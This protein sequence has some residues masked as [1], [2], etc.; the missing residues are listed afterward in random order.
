[1]PKHE[2][3]QGTAAGRPAKDDFRC[4]AFGR[5]CA[6]RA[7]DSGRWHPAAT[8][9]VP[10]TAWNSKRNGTAGALASRTPAPTVNST[11]TAMS[12]LGQGQIVGEPGSGLDALRGRRHRDGGGRRD[13]CGARWPAFIRHPPV[14]RLRR[15]RG[16]ERCSTL[17]RRLGAV[18]TGEAEQPVRLWSRRST[19]PKPDGRSEQCPVR[20]VDRHEFRQG[21]GTET[22]ASR[23][24]RR[25]SAGCRPRRRADH[26]VATSHRLSLLAR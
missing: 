26:A 19:C 24:R 1:M 23:P 18:R 11:S 14:A 7:T 8:R 2:H 21:A 13:F 3:L 9:A 22:A 10:K 15:L 17:L 6:A 4:G 16:R 20:G 12:R 5:R 25:E